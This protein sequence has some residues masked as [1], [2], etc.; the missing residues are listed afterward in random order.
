MLKAS[1][2]QFMLVQVFSQNDSNYVLVYF[3]FLWGCSIFFGYFM[4]LICDSYKNLV[5]RVKFATDR[6]S[7]T[8]V[9]TSLAS[10]QTRK[11]H[12]HLVVH[13][14]FIPQPPQH[15]RASASAID[16]DDE[17]PVV[18]DLPC[19]RH[20]PLLSLLFPLHPSSCSSLTL[21]L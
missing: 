18:P 1:S 13:C 3:P 14:R 7:P 16:V 10:Q 8:S 11:A 2:R 5:I 19:L 6:P 17:A 4:N 9:P 21:E 15:I 12:G 20:R